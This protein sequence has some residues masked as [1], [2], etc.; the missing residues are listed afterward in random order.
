MVGIEPMTSR[1]TLEVRDQSRLSINFHAWK[2][3]TAGHR[4][5]N[6]SLSWQLIGVVLTCVDL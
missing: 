5:Q 6:V 4:C 3:V 2:V 1:A